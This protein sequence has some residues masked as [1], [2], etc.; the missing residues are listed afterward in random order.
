VRWLAGALLYTPFMNRPNTQR[1]QQLWEYG[2]I[3]ALL[4]FFPVVWLSIGLGERSEQKAHRAVLH[5]LN[6]LLTGFV[7]EVNGQTINSPSRII[8]DLKMLRRTHDH[9]P[10]RNPTWYRID[11]KHEQQVLTLLLARMEN[12]KDKYWV[13]LPAAHS[14]PSRPVS[15]A[16]LGTRIGTFVDPQ[17]AAAL[18]EYERR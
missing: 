8:T 17:L 5:Q 18:A 6:V 11:I 16:P 10:G 4:I 2:V 3:L 14:T 13:F 15:A 7:L 12:P 9:A 1:A